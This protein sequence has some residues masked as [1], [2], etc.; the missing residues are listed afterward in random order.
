MWK[1]EIEK[2]TEQ[3]IKSLGKAFVVCIA[4]AIAI[5][6]ANAILWNRPR[7]IPS[8]LKFINPL[9]YHTPCS[10]GLTCG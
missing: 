2:M 9:R 5:V 1:K 7:L 10:A 3:D 8:T 4:L 6:V